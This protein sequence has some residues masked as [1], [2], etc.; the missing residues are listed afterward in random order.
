MGDEK[1]ERE[2][3]GKGKENFMYQ[4]TGVQI[5]LVLGH[6]GNNSSKLA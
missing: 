2:V 6:Q 1:I 4:D 5:D 3:K